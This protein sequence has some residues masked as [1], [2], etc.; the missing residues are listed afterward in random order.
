[1]TY[2]TICLCSYLLICYWFGLN[3][4]DSTEQSNNKE[5]S[6]TSDF[7]TGGIFLH[8]RSWTHSLHHTDTESHD[9]NMVLFLILLEY[10]LLLFKN[11]LS[12]YNFGQLLL[13]IG[14]FWSDFLHADRSLQGS[15]FLLYVV[16]YEVCSLGYVL[17]SMIYQAHE[18]FC[19]K[20]TNIHVNSDGAVILPSTAGR[21]SILNFGKHLH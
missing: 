12:L 21:S 1:M 10:Y 8:R 5:L 4:F 2:Y 14:Q 19:F 6:N 11:H 13:C 16:S 3:P 15:Y 9:P 17:N 20:I 7:Y 18:V